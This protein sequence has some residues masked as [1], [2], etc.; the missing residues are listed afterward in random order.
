MQQATR[1]ASGTRALGAEDGF[2][3]NSRTTLR[4]AKQT[5]TGDCDP[6]AIQ[7]EKTPVPVPS[8]RGRKSMGA[9]ERKVVAER[10]KIYWAEERQHDTNKPRGDS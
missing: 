7:Q 6:G 10:M 2:D 4:G 3:P 1:G 5:P 8:T 9:E